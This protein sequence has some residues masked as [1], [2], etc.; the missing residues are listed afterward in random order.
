M[1]DIRLL[2]VV[3]EVEHSLPSSVGSEEV[4]ADHGLWPAGIRLPTHCLAVA[5][6]GK[7]EDEHRRVGRE[8]QS[9][10]CRLPAGRDLRDRL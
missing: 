5:I 8:L 7:R 6:G 1:G 2:V 9:G 3:R 4:A 10:S